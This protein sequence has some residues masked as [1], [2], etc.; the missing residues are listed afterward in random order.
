M[1]DLVAVSA[2]AHRYPRL[3]ERAQDGLIG[4]TR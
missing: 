3:F 4:L 1:T 2:R